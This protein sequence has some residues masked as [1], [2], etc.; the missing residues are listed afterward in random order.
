L[1]EEHNIEKACQV[2]KYFGRHPWI[3]ET[4]V[5]ALI[6]DY[7]KILMRRVFSALTKEID[8]NSSYFEVRARTLTK[9]AFKGMK[10]SWSK[11][12]ILNMKLI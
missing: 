5:E 11:T 6:K 8:Q 12:K 7:R 2:V 3:T 4:N 9:Q 10:S 1:I